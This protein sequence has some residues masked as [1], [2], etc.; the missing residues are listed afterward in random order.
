MDNSVIR[1]SELL[2][3]LYFCICYV[4]WINWIVSGI[5][6]NWEWF[7][8]EIFEQHERYYFEFTRPRIHGGTF[9]G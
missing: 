7:T 8:R 2:R 1:G 5:F 3:M 9:K 4:E 6:K